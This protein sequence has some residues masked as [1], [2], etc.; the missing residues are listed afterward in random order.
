MNAP[1]CGREMPSN[2]CTGGSN[3]GGW[4]AAMLTVAVF[5]GGVATA[6]WPTLRYGFITVGFGSAATAGTYAAGLCLTRR[7]HPRDQS[8]RRLAHH[9]S[10]TTSWPI[11][12]STV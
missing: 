10:M 6:N 7:P 1:V 8:C 12:L 9:I 4:P 2:S 11:V 3:L 5:A